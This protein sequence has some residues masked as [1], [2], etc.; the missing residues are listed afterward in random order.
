MSSPSSTFP[1][2]AYS[3]GY[4]SVALSSSLSHFDNQ[5][6]AMQSFEQ[7]PY[8][9]PNTVNALNNLNYDNNG[10]KGRIVGDVVV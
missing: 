2:T 9:P 1:S 3:T 5:A 8:N 4:I 7:T 6:V 10:S